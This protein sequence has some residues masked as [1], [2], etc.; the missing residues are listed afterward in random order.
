MET[1]LA[2]ISAEVI[3]GPKGPTVLI[4]ERINPTG[5]KRLAAALSDG[6]LTVV[7]EEARAQAAQGADII[8]VN[9]GAAD[10]DE[11]ALLA[12]AVRLA[13]EATGLP[14]A[15]DSSSVDALE[16]ALKACPGKPLV[17]SVNG[18]DGSLR[19][20]L[21]LVKE[22]SAAVIG[23]TMDKSGIPK[24]PEGRLAVAENILSQAV[25]QGIA[26]EDVII[27][28]LALSVGADQQAALITLESIRLIGRE[29][30]VN[31]TLGGSNVSFG[32]PQR[33]AVNDIFLALAIAAGVNCPIANP[34]LARRAILVADLL[35]G[36]DEYARRYIAHCRASG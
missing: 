22:R 28:P 21:P 17:N 15:V 2:G 26:P 13:A 1:R 5:R 31:M 18:E 29:L 36:R 10:V 6:D 35:L 32:L 16:A 30:G 33:G 20:V 19:S 14:I 34:A 23:L 4:G 11:T 27:D 12:R 9:V 25:K 8:D 7:E 24:S 3:I